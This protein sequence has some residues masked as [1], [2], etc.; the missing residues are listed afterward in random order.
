MCIAFLARWVTCHSLTI[1]IAGWSSTDAV[2]HRWSLMSG[3]LL[4]GQMLSVFRGRRGRYRVNECH[5][6]R[7]QVHPRAHARTAKI[8]ARSVPMAVTVIALLWRNLEL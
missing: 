5:N 3:Y 6:L 2:R 8:E 7:G 1:C 4:M